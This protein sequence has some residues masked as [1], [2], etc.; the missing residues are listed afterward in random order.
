MG[1]T[2]RMLILSTSR[3]VIPNVICGL[4]LFIIIIRVMKGEEHE[5]QPFLRPSSGKRKIWL[6]T[7]ITAALVFIIAGVVVAVYSFVLSD[8]PNIV[9]NPESEY[10]ERAHRLLYECVILRQF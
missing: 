8:T 4:L 5:T 7:A 3:T 2:S 1:S 10:L 9:T 6:Y